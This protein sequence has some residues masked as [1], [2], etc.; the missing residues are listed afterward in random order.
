MCGILGIWNCRDAATELVYGLTTLQ[1][2][3]QDAA[4][5]VTFDGSFHLKKGHGL[6]SQVFEEKHL[7]RLRGACGLGH[8]RYATMGS[9]DAL[10]AQPIYVNYPY[11]LA[12]VHNG[13]VV[14][15]AELRE[16]LLH[17]HHRIVDTSNDVAL[18]LYTLAA[19]L[20]KTDLRAM[21][22]DVLFSCVEATQCEV[23]G[24][25]SAIAII[26]NRGLLAFIDPHGFRP[27]TLGSKTTADGTTYA[28]A[29]ESTFFDYLGYETLG[30]L[31]PGEALFIDREGKIYRHQ[32]PR[33][34]SAF[35]VFEYIYFARE[36]SILRGRL[37]ADERVRMG[38]ALGEAVQA[39][40]LRPDTVIDVPASGY[41]FA[42]ALAE[43]LGIPYRRGLAK[44]PHVG[45][46]FIT[47][48]QVQ[49]ERVVHQK[50][51]PIA[52]VVRGRKVAVVDD[53]IVRGTTSKRLVELLRTAGA[54]E[55]YFIS[56]APPI[57]YPCVY[58][59]DMSTHE[60][61]IASARSVD[62]V[63]KFIGADALVYQPLE[64]LR[65]LYADF[66]CCTA[67]FSGE[68]PTGDHPDVLTRIAQEKASS[69]R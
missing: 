57:R 47:A 17:E 29:S 6:V 58:G 59:I 63:M 54:K 28:L 35:C 16:R 30:D 10:D 66:G 26:A 42:S 44:N 18:I 46:S 38:R 67:C 13:N 15:F 53:S 11:G 14:N 22:I 39:A 8:V 41:F 33:M 27:L 31:A 62:E 61:L 20:E 24:A 43:A 34:Q 4:G 19:H 49:R 36:D 68:Y 56:A 50:L 40:G 5:V 37:V 51:N 32:G 7:Q 23:G 64:V 2:R 52:P 55:V 69:D 3:G 21:S 12:M 45:R 1:H 25:Y 65:S 48:T 60:E 9:T